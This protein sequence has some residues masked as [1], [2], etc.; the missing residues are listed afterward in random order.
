MNQLRSRFPARFAYATLAIGAASV[1]VGLVG[2]GCASESEVEST[3]GQVAEAQQELSTCVTLQRGTFGNVEDT[4]IVPSIT[5]PGW[6]GDLVEMHSGC[7][8][9]ALVK[10]DVS[11]IPTNATVTSATLGL[12]SLDSIYNATIFARYALAPWTESTASFDSFNQQAYSQTMGSMVA[13]TPRAAQTMGLTPAT[14]QGWVDGSLANNGLVLEAMMS[15]SPDYSSWQQAN[16]ET[17]NSPTVAHRPA[18]TV[19]YTPFMTGSTSGAGESGSTS[20]TSGAGGSGSTSST[21]GAGGSGST[22]TVENIY[23][24]DEFTGSSLDPSWSIVNGNNFSYSVSNGALGLRP[25][26]NTLWWMGDATG[27]LVHK[28]VTGN[29]KI[30][31]AVRARRASKTSLAVGPTDYQFGGI[32]ARAPN[33]TSQNYVFGVIGDRGNLQ[34]ETKSTINNESQVNAKDWPSGDAQLRLCRV[35]SMIHVLS[36]PISGGSWAIAAPWGPP[37]ERPDLPQTLQ[38]GPIA[39]TWTNSPDLRAS[40]DYVRYAPVASAADCTVD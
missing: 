12:H 3:E 8:D 31:T 1:S 7:C 28:L 6:G 17:S 38:V 2:S 21:S 26:T 32:M 23:K 39:Y 11:S 4:T 30:T 10:F 16:F 40:F 34:V 5:Y 33:S 27:A 24:G 37:Y 25:T 9:E 19:C 18:L 22:S 15:Q 36:R 13:S 29:F 20:S 35:G 14:V